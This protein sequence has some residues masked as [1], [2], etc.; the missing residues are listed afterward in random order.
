MIIGV[1]I[2]DTIKITELTLRPGSPKSMASWPDLE[3]RAALQELTENHR[4]VYITSRM[5]T[6]RL[7]TVLWLR[8][9]GF[10]NPESVFFSNFGSKGE[11]LCSLGVEVFVDDDPENI[12]EAV[13]LGIESILV[14]RWYNKD[15]D[16]QGVVRAADWDEI[17]RWIK[18]RG[19][20]QE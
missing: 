6:T 2:D 14:D 11:I 17:L 16:F 8:D 12:Q 3:A 4:V 9:N 7:E 5:E 10:P 18:E 20:D 1:D 19:C 15:F 13:D